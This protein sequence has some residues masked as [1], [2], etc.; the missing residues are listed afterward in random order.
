[1][2]GIASGILSGAAGLVGYQGAQ[3]AANATL[4]GSQTAAAGAELQGEAARN[5]AVYRAAQLRRNAQLARAGAQGDAFEVQRQTDA[6]Q[7]TLRARAAASG[8]GVSD[9]TVVALAGQIAQRGALG[10]LTSM[11]KGETEATGLE[12]TAK[13]AE[14]TGQ[15]E[16]QGS[17][18][19]AAGLRAEGEMRAESQRKQGVETLLSAG[20]T[21]FGRFG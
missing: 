16:Y 19:K 13:A 8:G 2:A 6:L 18:I 12:D 1:M 5:A 9:P 20:S 3:D 11:F 17:Q 4:L 14:Y 7:S 21:M 10:A 15:A